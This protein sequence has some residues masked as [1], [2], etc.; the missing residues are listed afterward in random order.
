MNHHPVQR[1][2][3]KK[4][5]SLVKFKAQN[6]F[7]TRF[8]CPICSYHGP[9]RNHNAKP[10][11]RKHAI[12]PK[13]GAKERHRL[14]FVVLHSVLAQINSSQLRMIHFAPETFFRTF[15]SARFAKYETADLDKQGVDHLVDLQSLPFS[16]NSY[17]FVFAS[18]VLEHIPD[19]ISAVKEI[20][21]VLSPNGIAILPVP[22]VSHKTVEYPKANPNEANHVRAPGFDYFDRYRAHFSRVELFSSDSFS[23]TNHQLH[24][25]EDR[26]KWP[27][28]ECPLRP[29]M[30]G[31]K[32]L[33]IIPVCFV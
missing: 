32:H 9:F 7:K 33:A 15:F 18:H 14:Q 24:I 2:S 23:G 29:P 20:K 3:L 8:D 10:G 11:L 16:D 27:T 4:R 13:C 12:C 1:L 31:E 6:L 28:R 26:Q 21:R 25:Y 17:D 30:E 5:L 19:D 22:V